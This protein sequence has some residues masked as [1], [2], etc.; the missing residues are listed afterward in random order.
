VIIRDCWGNFVA[1]SNNFISHV[2]DVHVAEA[3][4]LK[5]GLL[6][7]KILAQVG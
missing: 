1:T 3:Y 5:D 4:A 6:L 7:A 2:A